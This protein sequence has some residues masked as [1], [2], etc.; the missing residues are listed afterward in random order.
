ML[1]LM[2]IQIE[3]FSV[4]VDTT[5]FIGGQSC[6]VYTFCEVLGGGGGVSTWGRSPG[7][8]RYPHSLSKYYFPKAC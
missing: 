4:I 2:M 6:A 3:L 8:Y 7:I 1:L 5:G